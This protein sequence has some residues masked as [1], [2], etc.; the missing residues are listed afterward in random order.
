MSRDQR[1][2]STP[3][4]RPPLPAASAP[5]AG[6]DTGNRSV[7]RLHALVADQVLGAARSRLPR[8]QVRVWG[9]VVDIRQ[10]DECWFIEL[11][12]AKVDGLLVT[13]SVP[14]D[15]VP[16][17]VG[18]TVGVDGHLRVRQEGSAVVVEVRGTGLVTAGVSSRSRARR[19]LLDEVRRST[20]APLDLSAYAGG[21]I[22][23]VTSGASRSLADFSRNLGFEPSALP[24]AFEEVR[25]NDPADVARG[26]AATS[27]RPGVGVVVLVRG[28]GDAGQLSVF[29]SPEVTRAVAGAAARVPVVVG[30][31][32]ASDW[33]LADEVASRS[34]S[35]PSQAAHLV[36]WAW[37]RHV[38]RARTPLLG[39]WRWRRRLRRRVA[40]GFA[41]LLAA[42][43]LWLAGGRGPRSS[44]D[45]S[46]PR[47]GH[48]APAPRPPPPPRPHVVPLPGR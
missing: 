32:H 46:A 13:A 26:L 44:D 43:A 25:L 21:D 48:T 34:A 40:I 15:V 33:T 6:L 20:P 37:R 1:S 38:E 27:V 29:S 12:D 14:L 30:V 11:M 23:L 16:P 28:G 35:T 42:L 31:G 10:G 17:E 4:G 5:G 2:A 8:D 22:V 39:R 19:A 3:T 7:R 41:L 9:E 45:S 24:L 36:A 18:H 47:T